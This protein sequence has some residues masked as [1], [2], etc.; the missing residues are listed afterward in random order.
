MTP[1][2]KQSRVIVEGPRDA[3]IPSLL[4]DLA[5]RDPAM[6]EK[7]R[8]ALVVMGKKAVPLLIPL[9]S[10]DKP[11]VRWEAAKALCGIA[12]PIAATA[13]VSALEDP[14]GDVRWLAAEGLIV[15]GRE[16]V[17]P[18][19]AALLERAQSFWLCK[20]A[21]HVCHALAIKRRLGPILRPVLAALDQPEPQ[22]GVP[23]A[24]YAALSKLREP[25]S[26]PGFNRELPIATMPA[27]VTSAKSSGN[28]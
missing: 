7:A 4:G 12:D 16:G 19:L 23:L 21:H 27:A 2:T 17:Q 18:L 25:P 6:R 8:E 15:L 5:G 1:P 20:S 13:L 10:H 9:L 24:A 26:L 3:G 11:H 22:V 14:D 28:S